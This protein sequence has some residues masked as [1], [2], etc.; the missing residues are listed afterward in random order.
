MGPISSR[1]P[2]AQYCITAVLYFP[3]HWICGELAPWP[4]CLTDVEATTNAPVYPSPLV[5]R[6]LF[7]C[8]VLPLYHVWRRLKLDVTRLPTG[9]GKQTYQSNPSDFWKAPLLLSSGRHVAG[10]RSTSCRPHEMAKSTVQPVGHSEVCSPILASCQLMRHIQRCVRRRS[11][12]RL[13]RFKCRT[14]LTCCSF[15]R[16]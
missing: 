4:R 12:V 10:H 11:F 13:Y 5:P 9:C 6:K 14:A 3:W 16:C 2:S 1:D 15:G 8:L 7:R